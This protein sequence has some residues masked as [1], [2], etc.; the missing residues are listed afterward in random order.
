L[1]CCKEIGG[2]DGEGGGRERKGYVLSV[3]Y[4]IEMSGWREKYF[5]LLL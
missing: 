4:L 1:R 2:I 3:A 5:A